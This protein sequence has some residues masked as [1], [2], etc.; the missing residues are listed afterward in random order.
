VATVA[1]GSAPEALALSLTGKTLYVTNI[2]D[3]T[4]SQY[5]VSNAGLLSPDSPATVAAGS[6]PF[7]L[8]VAQSLRFPRVTSV[9]VIDAFGDAVSQYTAAAN[10]TL[11]PKS[12]A[13]V[14]TG[15]DPTGVAVDVKT[16]SVYVDDFEGMNLIQYSAA[17]NGTLAPV[18]SV[19]T[20]ANPEGI[21]VR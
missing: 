8:A 18:T 17:S 15:L 11:S 2:G 7:T 6:G 13:T 19:P 14:P 16:R 4:V 12:P 10:G 20:A 5:S 21:A 3:D 9:Y 1:A